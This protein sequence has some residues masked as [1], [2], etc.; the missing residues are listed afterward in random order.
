MPPYLDF[1]RWTDCS[2]TPCLRAR[3]AAEAPASRSLRIEMICSSEY[4]LCFMRCH[5]SGQDGGKTPFAH[6]PVYG[7]KINS[8]GWIKEATGFRRLS[9]RGL[10]KARGEWDLAYLALNVKRMGH[11]AAG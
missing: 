11:L 4:R 5:P 3:S 10:A 2:A 9:V 8:N 6:G 1:Q 7:G